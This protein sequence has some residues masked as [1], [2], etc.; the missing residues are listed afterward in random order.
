MMRYRIE[1][2]IT[3]RWEGEAE[4]ICVAEKRADEDS[5]TVYYNRYVLKLEDDGTDL[6][7]DANEAD[8]SFE[9]KKA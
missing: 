4:D 5:K 7:I 8:A 1:T 2:T 9:E 6:R 3:E